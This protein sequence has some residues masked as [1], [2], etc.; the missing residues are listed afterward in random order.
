MYLADLIKLNYFY[1]VHLSYLYTFDYEF[2]SSNILPHVLSADSQ[3]GRYFLGAP[4]S[5]P[6]FNYEP[7]MSQFILYTVK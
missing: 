1:S 2:V 3:A 6:L 7:L 5:S 4:E